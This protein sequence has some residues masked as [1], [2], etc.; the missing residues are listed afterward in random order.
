MKMRSNIPFSVETVDEK[1]LMEGAIFLFE[2]PKHSVR[3]SA[4]LHR[5]VLA[6]EGIYIVFCY[7]K[8]SEGFENQHIYK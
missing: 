7:G 8:F 1:I 3:V 2:K 6:S 5:T 4:R